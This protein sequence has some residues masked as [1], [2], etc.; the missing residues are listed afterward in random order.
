MS[1]GNFAPVQVAQAAEK[2]I[3]KMDE[4]VLARALAQSQT[5]LTPAARAN[6]VEAI[7]GAFR[8][9]GESSQDAAEGAGTT[10]D[11]LEAGDP[12]AVD[13]LMRYARENPGLLKDAATKLIARDPQILRQLPPELGDGISQLLD[14][15][16]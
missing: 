7:I 6:L 15:H 10:L 16:V 12:Q 2:F 3:G 8:G 1:F 4:A 11:S 5:Q 13:A 14:R 9:R